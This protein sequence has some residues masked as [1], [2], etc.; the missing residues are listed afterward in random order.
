[1]ETE[2]R[3]RLDPT[4]LILLRFRGD[5]RPFSCYY[6]SSSN[7]PTMTTSTRL[8]Y[9]CPSNYRF[10]VVCLMPDGKESEH[11]CD[12]KEIAHGVARSMR[13]RN[14]TASRVVV[15]EHSPTATEF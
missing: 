5:G 8:E 14:P 6:L 13:D 10:Q 2:R 9:P 3:A 1:M 11:W 4:P 12:L 15:Y 7:Q